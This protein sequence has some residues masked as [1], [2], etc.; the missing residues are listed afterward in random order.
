MIETSPIDKIVRSVLHHPRVEALGLTVIKGVLLNLNQ[1]LREQRIAG[2]W[3]AAAIVPVTSRDCFEIVQRVRDEMRSAYVQV[4]NPDRV[5][6]KDHVILSLQN[7]VAAHQHGYNKMN[8]VDSELLLVMAGVN[9]FEMAVK[10]LAPKD[11]GDVVLVAFSANKDEALESVR[12]FEKYA[13]SRA[14]E[15]AFS[16]SGPRLSTL[17]EMYG[18]PKDSLAEL[19]EEELAKALAERGAIFYAKYR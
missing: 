7:V 4:I 11:K 18:I 15:L 3:A 2:G 5:L 16:N 1:L 19:S 14:R 17:V 8:R 12:L 13:D 6:N 9:N 10:A